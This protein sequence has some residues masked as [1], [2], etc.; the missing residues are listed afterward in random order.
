MSIEKLKNQLEFLSNHPYF[1][2]EWSAENDGAFML[3]A[4]RTEISQL[5]F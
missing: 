2:Q 1:P 5:E 4:R 3:R